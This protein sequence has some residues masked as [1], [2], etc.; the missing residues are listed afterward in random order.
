MLWC[1]VD[2]QNQAVWDFFNSTALIEKSQL[3]KAE[4]VHG[5]GAA[6]AGFWTQT[7]GFKI[8]TKTHLDIFTMENCSFLI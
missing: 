5:K 1:G 4:A 6:S 8:I 7:K 3:V 2:P